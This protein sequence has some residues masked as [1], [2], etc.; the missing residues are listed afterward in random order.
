MASAAAQASAGGRF[1][2]PV[3]SDND[4]EDENDE[5]DEDKD[6]ALGGSRGGSWEPGSGRSSSGGGSPRGESAAPGAGEPR[7]TPADPV[8]L[9]DAGTLEELALFSD[10]GWGDV[11]SGV[12]GSLAPPKGQA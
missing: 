11:M 2:A 3:D 12:A 4:E 6:I 1:G 7:G 9:V 8:G 10:W 5:G